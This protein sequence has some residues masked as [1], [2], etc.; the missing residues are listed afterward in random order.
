MYLLASHQNLKMQCFRSK[1][2]NLGLCLAWKKMAFDAPSPSFLE[3][4]I[5]NFLLDMVA[6]MQGG[7]GQEVSVNISQYQYKCLK[8][9]PEP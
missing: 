5:V 3:N 6:F 1:I 4:Y 7:I 2:S 8:T 9:Y